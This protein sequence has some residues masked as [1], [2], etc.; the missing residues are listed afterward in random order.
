MFDKFFFN[1]FALTF[2]IS[3]IYIFKNLYLANNFLNYLKKKNIFNNFE[4][5]FL[6]CFYLI[7]LIECFIFNWFVFFNF[8]I[9]IF[10]IYFILK[11]TYFLF[12]LF[13][14]SKRINFTN[15][16]NIFKSLKLEYKIILLL[17][18]Y[19]SLLPIS[20][21]DSIY[22]HLN[23]PITYLFDDLKIFISFQS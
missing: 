17:F 15:I 20:D 3:C 9:N 2:I 21:A 7:F 16:F 23:F 19:I 4:F 11:T 5:N 10:Y 8:K 22:I 1:S 6:V 12:L 18:F 14:K 13:K